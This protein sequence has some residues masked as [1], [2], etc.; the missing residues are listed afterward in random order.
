[1][2]TWVRMP[3][4]CGE[5]VQGTIDGIDLHITCPVSMYS[6]ASASRLRGGGLKIP[7]N[8]DKTALAVGKVL[9]L[10]G[11]GYGIEIDV[12][13][14]L[15]RG[16]GMASS[17]AD[18]AA[19]VAATY[20]LLRKDIR[21]ED[22]ANVAL[23]IEP[24]DGTFFKGIVAFDHKYGRRFEPIGEAPPIEIIVL[25]PP[26]VIDTITFNRE[27]KAIKEMDE[28]LVKEAFE[29]AVEGIKTS[30]IRLV[31]KAATISAIHNQKILPK[32]ALGDIIDI[33]RRK[34]GIGVNVAHSGTVAGMMVEKGFGRRLFERTAHY[35]P[36]S[37]DAYLVSMVDGG[38]RHDEFEPALAAGPR[39]DSITWD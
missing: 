20:S 12:K 29:M 26:E 33:C 6:L 16:K 28:V 9:E 35:M 23:S 13:S 14:E 1:M 3:G 15:P 10:I 7:E 24:T 4:S 25:E 36:G 5:L 31:G 17:T 18:I 2:M 37:W 30:N 19:A 11:G 8:L 21:P 22:I 34:G 27:R 32:K 39:N 38:L